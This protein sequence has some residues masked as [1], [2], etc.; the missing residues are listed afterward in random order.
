MGFSASQLISANLRFILKGN[1]I[2]FSIRFKSLQNFYYLRVIFKVDGSSSKIEGCNRTPLRGPYSQQCSVPAISSCVI[3][4]QNIPTLIV[5]FYQVYS[6]HFRKRGLL[7]LAMAHVY[8]LIKL[9]LQIKSYILILLLFSE[10]WNVLASV[11]R[12]KGNLI[13]SFDL[14]KKISEY[15]WRL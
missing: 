4:S 7:S 14:Q 1:K 3:P 15:I 8:R 2:H 12:V 13:E 9:K 11:K 6:I 10:H 5:L